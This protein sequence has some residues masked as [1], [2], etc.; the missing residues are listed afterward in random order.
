MSPLLCVG[1]FVCGGV[2]MSACACVFMCVNVR[3][4]V[5]CGG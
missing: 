2:V 4:Y 3:V 5:W 1:V